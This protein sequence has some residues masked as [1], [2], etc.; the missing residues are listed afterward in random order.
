MRRAASPLSGRHV[1]S[2]Q[3][4]HVCYDDP[5]LD[6]AKNGRKRDWTQMQYAIQC[7]I[8]FYGCNLNLRML[9][10]AHNCGH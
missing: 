3:G 6:N 7:D 8:D 9:L 1:A 4:E 10:G 2:D 5:T